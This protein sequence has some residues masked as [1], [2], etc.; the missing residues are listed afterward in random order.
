MAFYDTTVDIFN[1]GP[2]DWRGRL[3]D[4]VE[5]VSPEG[6]EFKAKWRGDSRTADKKLGIFIYPRVKGNIVQDLEVNS[7][8]YSIPLYFDGKDCDLNAQS[9]FRAARENGP[10]T[11]TH[12]VYGFL[13]LQL[14]SI[15][16][17]ADLV[18]NGGYVLV[19]TE[20][21]E[22][23]D[24]TTLQTTA[25]MAAD[26][27]GET[28][29]LNITA[30]EQFAADLDATTEALR[31]NIES[32]V[33]GIENLSD[34]ALGPLFSIT[35]SLDNLILSIHNGIQDTLDAAILDP[36]V[37][38]AQIQNLL[39]TPLLA[40]NDIAARLDYYGDLADD[41]L[42][43]LPDAS[44][45]KRK[46]F[47]NSV[48]TELALSSITV[49]NAK[50]ATTGINAAQ[51]GRAVASGRLSAAQILSGVSPSIQTIPGASTITVTTTSPVQTRAQ[52]VEAAQ[53]IADDFAASVAALEESQS[54]FEGLDID[55]QYFSQKQTYA[56]ASKIVARTVQFLLLSAFD[57]AVERRFTLDRPRSPI[58]IT[59]SEYG[60]LGEND[61]YLDLFIASNELR[62][63]DI[64]LLPAGREVVIYG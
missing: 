63:D 26:I 36:L 28:D 10:W 11:V 37:L 51:S 2:D 61:A 21:I 42:E 27:F 17:S 5:L 32:T 1:R 56:L 29:T 64:Y 41:L 7:T 34:A 9:F 6:S 24:E 48:I 52:V 4:S 8:R 13:E 23:I 16:E 39:Q 60:T 3:G 33:N 19:E 40:M 38:G 46:H 47:N 35:D 57:L 44:S 58:D 14:I 55:Q 49:A 31:E 20:W 30:A 18:A 62:G 22:P 54:N 25:E 59:I 45:T 50:I 43:I 15:K 53:R 12:P